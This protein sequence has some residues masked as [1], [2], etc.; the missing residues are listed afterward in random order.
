MAGR[1]GAVRTVAYL[2]DAVE[3]DERI[4]VRL[5]AL[6]WEEL[7]RDFDRAAEFDQSQL[8]TKVYSEEYGDR[9]SVV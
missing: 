5:L 1:P 8:F 2:L 7:G 4:K 9:K 3:G 6:T